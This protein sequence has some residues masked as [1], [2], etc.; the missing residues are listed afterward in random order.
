MVWGLLTSLG[1]T[2]LPE[3]LVQ[4]TNCYSGW[5]I[6]AYFVGYLSVTGGLAAVTGLLSVLAAD[7]GFYTGMW[8]QFGIIGSWTGDTYYMIGALMFG[9]LLGL[10]GYLF[11][12]RSRW[13]T[14]GV[15]LMASLFFSEALYRL[16]K[17][18]VVTSGFSDGWYVF[19]I[20]GVGFLLATLPRTRHQPLPLL[21][22]I[23][24]TAFAFVGVAL[25]LPVVLSLF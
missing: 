16:S 2:Y 5:L 24:L 12:T 25:V 21:S 1:Q 3:P 6:I 8:V 13:A 17:T 11:K 15:A 9:P 14:Y 22:I 10:A 20:L 19:A 4:L 7:V 18:D 23:P